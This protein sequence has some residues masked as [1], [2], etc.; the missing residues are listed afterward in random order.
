MVEGKEGRCEM[1]LYD[2][3]LAARSE[4]HREGRTIEALHLGYQAYDDFIDAQ[5]KASR[6]PLSGFWRGIELCDGLDGTGPNYASI[7]Y[8]FEER[9]CAIMFKVIQ[10]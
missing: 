8:K 1:T 4:L 10:H 6:V 2:K 5:F 9:A 3:I 7:R